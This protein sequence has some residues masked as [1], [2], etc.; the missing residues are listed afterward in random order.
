M[1]TNTVIS[2]TDTITDVEQMRAL[3]WSVQVNAHQ[4]CQDHADKHF[5]GEDGG[6]CGFAWVDI[7]SYRGKKLDGR[8]K[9]GKILEKAGVGK[10]WKG[11]YMIWN[12]AKFPAQS[13]DILRAGAIEAASIL[14]AY[15]F[16][17]HAGSRI[18]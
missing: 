11:C 8:T 1:T 7:Y 4:A 10:S 13:I 3:L 9:M 14:R 6:A 18:D 16:D 15:G 2:S 12:P 5:G 17:A